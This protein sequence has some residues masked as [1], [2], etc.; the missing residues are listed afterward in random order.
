MRVY[1]DHSCFAALGTVFDVNEYTVIDAYKNQ[2][3]DD[4]KHTQFYLECLQQL[5]SSLHNRVLNQY[6]ESE[7]AKGIYT[8]FELDR[9]YKTLEIDDPGQIDDDGINVVFSIRCEEAPHREKDFKRA[10]QVI[11]YF[12]K[13]GENPEDGSST[14]EKKGHAMREIS[15]G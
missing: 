8:R 9:A 13:A 11:Q 3:T 14:P 4:P 7:F 12:K 10:M 5:G 1:S 6:V 15:D 2:I